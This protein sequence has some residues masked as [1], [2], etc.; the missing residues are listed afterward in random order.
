M[1][2]TKQFTHTS[3]GFLRTDKDAPLP[4]TVQSL[5]ASYGSKQYELKDHLG[6]VRATLSDRL[7]VLPSGLRAPE[8]LSAT[9]FYPFGMEMPS[10][11]YNANG[12]RYGFN[13]ME[14]DDELKGS[15]NS[16]EFGARIYDPRI[17]R[18]M[19]ID[20]LVKKYP[21]Q[22]S[23]CFAGNNP[24][25]YI[26]KNGEFAYPKG[27]EQFYRDNY[28]VIT[29]YLEN[30]I[31]EIKSSTSIINNLSKY[32]RGQLSRPVVE[33]DIQ[34]GNGPVIRFVDNPGGVKTAA[35]KF[36]SM[37]GELEI[38]S[39]IVTW[40]ENSSPEDK[41]AILIGVIGTI[42]HEYVHEGDDRDGSDYDEGIDNMGNP[43]NDEEGAQFTKAVYGMYGPTF[44][45]ILDEN[46]E[47]YI[48]LGKAIIEMRSGKNEFLGETE[49]DESV[50]PTVK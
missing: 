26:D 5:S 46:K 4:R 19:S 43:I 32:T 36:N 27:K 12:Y 6:N 39:K 2:T 41:Q 33:K 38:N 28:S 17:G 22:S 10:R 16:Y 14:K 48:E 34:F 30:G 49:K 1:Q 15:G 45:P 40:L 24:I 47:S 44:P 37:S 23:Y 25:F 31:S 13:G 8:L 7:T 35:G 18:F 20:P 50:I 11:S 3:S 29:S 9:D 42:L 21:F